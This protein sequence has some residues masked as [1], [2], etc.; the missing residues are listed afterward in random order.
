MAEY[1]DREALL[2]A[3]HKLDSNTG[4]AVLY[5]EDV[6]DFIRDFPAADVAPVRH[7]RWF[8][9]TESI[10]DT[11]TDEY[12]DEVYY[13]CNLCDYAADIKTPYCPICG[14]RMDLGGADN[15]R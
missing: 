11:H 1:I 3:A 2:S 9:L 15:I 14:S 6:L 13:N 10:H 7:G 5:T 8:E 12:Y 4:V